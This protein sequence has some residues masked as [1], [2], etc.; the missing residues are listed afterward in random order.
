MKNK[1]EIIKDL[2]TNNRS[3]YKTREVSFEKSYPD[4]Y[5]L[6]KLIDFTDSWYE[7][8]YCYLKNL[9]E[10]PKCIVCDRS[11]NFNRYSEGYYTYCSI[12]C[13]NNDPK[14]KMIGDINPMK[15]KSVI[16]LV[17]ETKKNRY[18]DENYVNVN[19]A[20]K[21]KDKRYGN[22]N[23]NN[24]EKAI[25]TSQKKHGVDNYT[26]REKAKETSFNRYGDEYYNNQKKTIK[27]NLVN[28]GVE[29]YM[30]TNEFKEKGDKTKFEK[31]G[32]ITY[33]KTIEYKQ[34]MYEKTKRNYAQKLN[35]SLDDIKYDG[36]VIEILNY[37]EIHNSF[38]I[39]KYAL[40]NRI[41]YGIG[42]VCTECNP[43]SEH[44]SIK[45]NELKLFI[46]T[47]N[48]DFIEN[49]RKILNGKEIDI[50][51]LENKLGIEFNGL[52]WHSDK[53]L[54]DNYHLN[55]TEE[56]EQQ[57]I[58][59]LH[60]FE[61]EWIF[62]KEIVKSIIKSK[63]GIIEN[64]IY[65]RK[66]EVKE[67]NDNGLIREF[68]ETNHLQGFVGSNIKIGLFHNNVLV[69]LMTFGKKRIAM[70]NKINNDNEYEMLRFCNKLNTQVIG[71][72]SKLL[73]YFV[74]TYQPKSILTFADRRY[75]NGD[76]YKQ[77]GFE[78]IGNTKPNY[79]YFKSHEYIRF[80]RFNFRKDILVSEGYDKNKTEREIMIERNYYRIYDSGNMK[81]IL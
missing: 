29:Y 54:T 12:K 80:Y 40:K 6:I 25:E 78:F 39:D 56:C 70:G 32:V 33:T 5:V 68:L 7:K 30:K 28:H 62:K 43:I 42:N 52:Y 27:T 24:R 53:Y 4:D 51:I 35:I 14:L 50:L 34:K 45:E 17:K 13:R 15:K 36:H 9:N 2:K 38:K 44:S 59:L 23:Y 49:D 20:K 79:W 81:F 31:Y 58:H 77:L 61:D 64:K 16:E 1:N 22:E 71:G 18:G 57:G 46:K 11:V 66:T 19:K 76:L 48:I 67:I 69:S 8:L 37:C 26:N 60:V 55:K 65:G 74:K 10:K 3:G 73:K 75:S 72:A 41:L 47:L 63:L 21:T